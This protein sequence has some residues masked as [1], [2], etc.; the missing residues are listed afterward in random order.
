VNAV[1]GPA[2]QTTAPAA[3]PARGPAATYALAGVVAGGSCL[4]FL[5]AVFVVAAAR[6]GAL[7]FGY[8]YPATF[9]LL[10]AAVVAAAGPPPL[11][12]V[13]ADGVAAHSGTLNT[14]MPLPSE[15]APAGPGRAAASKAPSASARVN[16]ESGMASH[17]RTGG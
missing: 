10:A 11:A 6:A 14:A 13:G 4:V 17:S 16:L 7:P 8:S 1:P 12:A 3:V 5:A 15:A 9:L 2:G